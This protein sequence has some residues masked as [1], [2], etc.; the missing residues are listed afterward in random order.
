MSSFESLPA[1][2]SIQDLAEHARVPVS[3][4]HRIVNELIEWGALERDQ[5]GG[6]HLGGRLTALV[7]RPST[8][9]RR[10]L[11]PHL[12]ELCAVTG[13]TVSLGLREGDQVR[14]S[15]RCYG[16]IETPRLTR[17]GSRVNLH[18]TAMGKILLAH[19]PQWFQDSFLS[20]DL[21]LSVFGEATDP[22]ELRQELTQIAAAGYV[23]TQ[24][25]IPEEVEVLAVP[26]FHHEK[27]S[28][29]I[30]LMRPTD[31]QSPFSDFL[32]ALEVAVSRIQSELDHFRTLPPWDND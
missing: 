6:V 26:V 23:H 11:Q 21:A 9:M 20:R 28:C 15:E 22:A 1:P 19:E 30:D 24:H 25:S 2:I 8:S 29:A 16:Q 14:V 18:L 32:P 31:A 5:N 12:E 17:V 10:L 3:T 4:T 13:H 27:I 7:A